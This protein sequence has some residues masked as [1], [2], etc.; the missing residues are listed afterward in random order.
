MLGLSTYSPAIVTAKQWYLGPGQQPQ[1]VA[2]GYDSELEDRLFDEIEWPTD[3]YRLFEIGHFIGDRDWFDGEWESNCIFI[4]RNLVEQIGGMDESFSAPGGGFVN[5]DFFERMVG[6]PGVTHV[7]MLGEGSFHQVHGGTTTNLA[8]PDQL[9][10]SFDDQYEELRGR[11]FQVP[12]QRA[13]FVGSLS[14]AARRT[15]ARRMNRF[16]VFRNAHIRAS[17]RRPSRPAP[18]PEDLRMDF[19]DAFW[20]S[21][22]WHRTKWLGKPTH[23]APTDLFV[24]QE[25]IFDL[26]P[27]WIVETRTGT[28][29]RTLF[30]ASICDLIG[31]GQVLSIDDYPLGD[32]PDHPRITYLR[33]APADERTAERVREIV[34]QAAVNLVVLGGAGGP[35]V[36]GAFRNLAPLVPV[37]SYVVIED[38][39]L[40]GNPVWP[41]FGSRPWVTVREIANKGEFVPDPT[42]ERLA[43]TFNAGGFLR[44]VR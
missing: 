42:L 9:I 17:D 39:I 2:G 1:T 21:G 33:A 15:K 7:T 20:R 38:T 22:E 12:M 31:T 16:D 14:P 23:R 27:D 43:L 13:H 44:R 37:G 3:G 5:L 35:Q 10:R 36:E 19:I 30:L 34:G 4:P 18:V 41:A 32:P 26:R 25:L 28:G 40:G 8:E 29:G 11:R 6:T 24:F